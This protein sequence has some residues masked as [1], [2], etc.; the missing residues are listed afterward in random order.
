M[1]RLVRTGLLLLALV[2]TY[3]VMLPSTWI[4]ALLQRA[5]QGTLAMTGSTGTFWR[6][7]GILQAIL[8]GGVAVT[9]VPVSW[10]IAPGELL[11]LKLHIRAQSA[12]DDT[13]VL[14]ATFGLGETDIQEATLELPAALLGVLSPTLLAADL[15]GQIAVHATDVRFDRSH[16]AGKARAYWKSA[17]SS[18]SR[19]HPL[20][21]YLLTLDGEGGGLDFRLTT[22]RGPLTLTGSGGWRPGKDPDIRVTAIPEQSARQDLVP[23]LR[24]MGREISPGAYQITMD[25][26]VQVIG[27]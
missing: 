15:S 7:E 26:N 4:D 16:A 10:T 1:K 24:V 27:R 18:L 5:S 13:P 20:G 23:M 6:G 19:I 14:N 3:L 2:V 8:P 21:N 22:M 12:R 9:L 25:Q 17:G 11:L